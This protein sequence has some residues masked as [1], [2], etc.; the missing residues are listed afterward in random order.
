M[1]KEHSLLQ[2]LIVLSI[3]MIFAGC[4]TGNGD[5]SGSGN[6]YLL[7]TSSYMSS[8]SATTG[9]SESS[10]SLS[11]GFDQDNY[12][13]FPVDGLPGDSDCPVDSGA[14]RPTSTSSAQSWYT[15]VWGGKYN[16]SFKNRCKGTGGH[17]GVDIRVVSGTAV[18][19]IGKGTVV[20]SKD[21]DSE[22]SWGGL[23]VIR[24]DISGV[25]GPIYSCYA[26]LKRRDVEKDA[27]IPYPGFSIGLSGGDASDPHHGN[28]DAAH[29]HF[30]IDKVMPDPYP[31]F[32]SQ[33]ESPD[34]NLA[35]NTYDP[36]KFIEDNHSIDVA[37]IIDSSGSMTSSDPGDMR[38]EAAKL[39]VDTAASNDQVAIID[40]DSYALLRWG[41]QELTDDRSSIKNAIDMI[42]S[43]GGTNISNA[44]QMAYDELNISTRSAKKAALLLTDGM[45]SYNNEASLFAT[46]S[47][48]VFTVGLGLSTDT[49]LLSEI[50]QETGGKYFALT[51]SNQL[52]NVYFEIATQ[53]AGG[54]L[55]MCTDTTMTTGDTYNTQITIPSNQQSLSFMFSWPGS[56]IGTTLVSPSGR[57]ISPSTNDSD[58]YH[59]KGL[60]YELYRL[61][62][63]EAGE[64]SVK[65]Y[66]AD[67]APQGEVVSISISSIGSP[68]S[69]SEPTNTVVT[70]E[71]ESNSGKGCFISTSTA[72][73]KTSHCL[74]TLLVFTGI[75]LGGLCTKNIFN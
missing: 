15:M 19:S 71:E 39:F 46:K 17:P 25:D 37:L 57:E 58:V 50:A 59:A 68:A 12:L 44:L 18:R 60:T 69:S 45:G 55:L 5:T 30:Q 35:G 34:P 3:F 56:D 54:S 65:V 14:A 28:S 62:N 66:G 16:G 75:V 70:E 21:Y 67:L 13:V 61:T 11:T 53:I 23:I 63:P 74:L 22:K 29:L 24:H 27:E 43:S 2:W 41:L 51:D 72:G 20:V 32:P 4:N 52:K 73:H 47:W 42:D 26:H 6:S 9:M 40:F 8:A 48:P 64:W 10:S 49:D 31:Y 33:T 38:K 36:I 1:N 7:E